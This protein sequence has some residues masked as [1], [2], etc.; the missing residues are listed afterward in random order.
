MQVQRTRTRKGLKQLREDKSRPTDLSEEQISWIT[1]HET[2]LQQVGLSI[3]ERR[4]QFLRRY[5]DRQIS[6]TK[7]R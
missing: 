6:V 5:P 1:S 4:A 2:H 3:A 7:Y